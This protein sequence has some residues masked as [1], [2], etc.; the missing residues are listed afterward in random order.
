MPIIGEV[1]WGE[2]NPLEAAPTLTEEEQDTLKKR[3]AAMDKLLVEKKRAKYK[4]EVTFSS[5]YRANQHYPGALSFWLSGSKLHGGGDE[6]I[7]LC[8]TCQVLILP[9]AQGYGHLVCAKCGVTWKGE[10]VK[11]EVF[12]RSTTQAWVHHLYFWFRA[13]D[14]DADL[15]IKRPK[16]DIRVAADLEQARQRGGEVLQKARRREVVIYPLYHLIKDTAA[17]ASIPDRIHAF[18]RA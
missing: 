10:Q 3:M 17:G 5:H 14:F 1:R 12:H 2:D 4:I 6:K 13:L 16:V 11:G 8:P 7:Y 15:Y 9:H 18:L